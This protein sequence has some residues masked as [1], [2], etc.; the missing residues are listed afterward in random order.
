VLTVDNSID[1]PVT[2]TYRME[3][4][5]DTLPTEINA[6]V[7]EALWFMHRNQFRFNGTT[8]GGS[9]GAIPMGRWDY[10][11]TSGQAEVTVSAAS[12]NAFEANGYLETGPAGSPYTFTVERGL[13][14]VISR[15]DDRA[16][17]PQPNCNA[18]GDGPDINGNG[19]GIGVQGTVHNNPAID[20]HATYK[21]GMVMDAIIASGT[22]GE[23]STTGF[24]GVIG[25]T[26]GDIIQDMAEYYFWSQGD[27]TGSTRGG[28][29]YGPNA[30]GDSSFGGLDNSSAGWAA[31]GLIAAEDVF[32]VTIPP[33]Y[34]S[35][36]ELAL[37]A[38][39]T[40]LQE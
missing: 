2:N 36:N 38:T 23:V 24:P 4:Q 29:D 33:C 15:L 37:E 7:D 10:P 35:E 6:A 39:D 34:K 40:L 17:T 19:V 31:I 28:W 8:T 9:G 27:T 30:A 12:V 21:M 22:P 1:P 13:L 20:D 3:C 16:I 25:K 14:Y 32:G 11:Q 26:Y 5:L 18:P